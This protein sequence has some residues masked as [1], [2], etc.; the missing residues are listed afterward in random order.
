M[1]GQTDAG[2]P[3]ALWDQAG[4][5]L[6]LTLNR[7]A[8]RNALSREMIAALSSALEAAEASPSV[9]VVVL[10]AV[11]PVFCAGH[12]LKE[13][14]AARSA[15]DQGE[16]FFTET[17]A[18]CSALMSRIAEGGKPVIAEV[19]GIATAAGCQLVASCDLAVASETARFA[20]PGVNIGLF[21]TTPAVALT[22]AVPP[23]R[24]LEMLL[25]GDAISALEAQGIGLINRV[26]S[27][28]TLTTQTMRLAAKI[29]EKPPAVV[30][31]G[32]RAVRDQ[33]GLTLEA[34]YRLANGVM[35]S[36]LGWTE[37]QDGIGAFLGGR[38]KD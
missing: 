26:V 10:A 17:F 7:P 16:A 9:R 32:R 28:D 35:V 37:A 30:A 13:L 29:A 5:V 22:R 31:L 3:L 33:A 38:T 20:T 6:R 2:A 14:T 25:T 19:Q 27:P 8:R 15:P 24:A 23:K 34:A 4:P 1:T 21:C 12:D 11:G 18:A 36:N